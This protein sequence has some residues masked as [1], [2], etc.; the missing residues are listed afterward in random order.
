M[1]PVSGTGKSATVHPTDDTE[2]VRAR[3]IGTQSVT[4]FELPT[5]EVLEMES[6]RYP[7]DVDDYKAELMMSMSES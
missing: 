7:F 2:L 3:G 4:L 5:P 1:K 6:V